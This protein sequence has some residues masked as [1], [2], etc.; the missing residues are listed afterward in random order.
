MVLRSKDLG[1]EI[2]VGDDVDLKRLIKAVAA[3]A[4]GYERH[5]VL[6][7]DPG[8]ARPVF[9]NEPWPSRGSNW[10]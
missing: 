7:A 8:Y 2:V 1:A 6:K 4:E 3:D 9:P 10:R 5:A